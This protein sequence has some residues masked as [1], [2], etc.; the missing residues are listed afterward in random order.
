M[1]DCV[2]L[3]PKFAHLFGVFRASQGLYHHSVFPSRF[4]TYGHLKTICWV[5][6]QVMPSIGSGATV[7]TPCLLTYHLSLSSHGPGYH[8]FD[9]LPHPSCFISYGTYWTFLSILSATAQSICPHLMAK[10][11]G[12]QVFSSSALNTSQDGSQLPTFNG[13]FKA[14][15]QQL[16][17]FLADNISSQSIHLVLWLPPHLTC[18]KCRLW[19]IWFLVINSLPSP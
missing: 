6:Q 18:L 9:F 7:D 16:L 3:T 5:R 4:Q 1:F 15:Q 11:P 13:T 12:A 8:H 2:H 17:V 14:P 10:Y 19:A